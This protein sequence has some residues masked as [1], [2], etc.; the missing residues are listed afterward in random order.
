MEVRGVVCNTLPA[1]S[2]HVVFLRWLSSFPDKLI[3]SVSLTPPHPTATVG[4]SITLICIAELSVDVSS[5]VIEFDFGSASISRA[6]YPSSTQFHIVTIS[7][8]SASSVDNYYKCTVTLTVLGVCGGGG[9]E[10]AC[11]TNTSNVVTPTVLCEWY[12]IYVY[13]SGIAIV[14][15]CAHYNCNDASLW[16]W[17]FGDYS[18]EISTIV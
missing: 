16:S 18:S 8:V 11:P 13:I 6:T 3:E 5:A 14:S 15:E 10:P 7:N 2:V 9:L 4:S 1:N 17:S 12:C